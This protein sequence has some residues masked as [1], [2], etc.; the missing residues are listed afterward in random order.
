M[1]LHSLQASTRFLG[2]AIVL[3]FSSFGFWSTR[4]SWRYAV[5]NIT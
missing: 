1:Q 2:T 4:S 5:D 3:F